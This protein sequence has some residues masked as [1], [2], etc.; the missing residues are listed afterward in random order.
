Q[1]TLSKDDTAI[2][3]DCLHEVIPRIQGPKNEDICYTTQ[4][5]QD[6]VKKRAERCDLILVVG[7]RNSSNSNRLREIAE[8]KRIDGYLIDSADDIKLEWLQNKTSIGVTAG[9]SAPELLVNNVVQ[10][11]QQQG[12][13]KASSLGFTEDVVFPLPKS[14]R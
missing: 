2:V 11:L 1:T 10:F 7:S 14:I 13:G 5:R 9:A 6:A 4:N 12:A 8:N 3:I